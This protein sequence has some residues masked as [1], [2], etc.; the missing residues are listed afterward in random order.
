MNCVTLQ[1]EDVC[2]LYY[3]SQ[4]GNALLCCFCSFKLIRLKATVALK[5]VLGLKCGV[6]GLLASHTDEQTMFFWYLCLQGGV[7][8]CLSAMWRLG[9][10]I[11]RKTHNS[12][13]FPFLMLQFK[14]ISI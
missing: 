9:P 8:C 5:L 2:S 13:Q 11:V 12:S 6:G 10:S 3:K 1:T 14:S 4:L 7:T